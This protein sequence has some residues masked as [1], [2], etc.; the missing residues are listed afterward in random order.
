M[1]SF[2]NIFLGA[3]LLFAGLVGAATTNRETKIKEL[4]ETNDELNQTGMKLIDQSGELAAS[5]S[6]KA[7][8]LKHM[9]GNEKKSSASCRTS[10]AQI[11]APP[12]L[13]ARTLS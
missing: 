9:R 7:A 11:H 4:S 3:A 5:S 13:T 2:S 1:V 6:T 10:Y 12:L 8:I